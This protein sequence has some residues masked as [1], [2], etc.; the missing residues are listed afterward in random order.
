MTRSEP[1]HMIY[2]T[3][4]EHGNHYK[5]HVIVCSRPLFIVSYNL[6][7]VILLYVFFICFCHFPQYL[8]PFSTEQIGWFQFLVFSLLGMLPFNNYIQSNIMNIEI[9]F[10]YCKN[11]STANTSFMYDL[12]KIYVTRNMSCTCDGTINF[13][14]VQSKNA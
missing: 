1:E 6:I 8:M 14:I 10:I 3:R 7:K 5:T 2:R 11:T 9:T 13:D 12:I 4:S